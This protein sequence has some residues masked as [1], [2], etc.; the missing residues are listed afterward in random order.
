VVSAREALSFT[1]VPEH[2]LV[3]G[4]GYIGLELGSVWRRLG[5][6]VTVVDILPVIL[7]AS[8]RQVADTLVRSLKK[9]GI[10]F[11]LDTKVERVSA[12]DGRAN[13]TLASGDS[14]E[15]LSCDKVLVAAGRTPLIAGLGL[16]EAGV[17]LGPDGRIVVDENYQTTAPGIYA[18]GDLVPGPMLAHKA[19]EEGVVA[20]ERMA[21]QAAF[22]EYDCIPGVVYTWPEAASVG[23]T[24]EQLQKEGIPYNSGRYSFMGN[25]RARAMDETEGFVKVLAH[26]DTARILGVHIVG[27]RASD[28]IAEAVAVVSFEGSAEDIALICHSHPTLSEALK[29]AALDSM[30][31][32]IHA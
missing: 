31:R 2:L 5:S 12:A 14:R 32:A 20:V 9:Q 26:A 15:E 25:G 19:S 21:G 29:E 1:V 10:T 24:E 11:R 4:G 22:V 28:L 7:P 13:V 16:E 6:R 8:D 17:R 18:I 3:V 23:K 30:K 27:P